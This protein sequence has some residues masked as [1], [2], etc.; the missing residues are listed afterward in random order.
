VNTPRR[1]LLPIPL[2]DVAI[3]QWQ[4]IPNLFIT[5]TSS[6]NIGCK[7]WIHSDISISIFC[8]NVD[9][10]A[11]PVLGKRKKRTN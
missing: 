1:T 10:V 3:A 11:S 9:E 7:V 4:I 6:E 8:N 2:G 5:N